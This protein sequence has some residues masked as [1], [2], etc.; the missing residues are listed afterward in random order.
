MKKKLVGADCIDEHICQPDNKLYADGSII[1]SPG[2]KD[3]LAKRGVSIVYGP[4]PDACN[5][6]VPLVCAP[7]CTCAVCTGG[8]GKGLERL[9]Y[10]VAATLKTEYGITDHEQLK[11]LSC[12]V[13]MT[14]KA[15]I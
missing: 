7:G 3:A 1:L 14:L 12:Q 6:S 13:L 9:F 8:M 5:A 15:N 11:E 4:R 10:A 2:A